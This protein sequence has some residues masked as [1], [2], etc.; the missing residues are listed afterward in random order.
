MQKQRHQLVFLLFRTDL[1]LRVVWLLLV[2][3]H[4]LS[5]LNKDSIEASLFAV[6]VVK[7]LVLHDE[8]VD[9]MN[10]NIASRREGLHSAEAL[11]VNGHGALEAQHP[12][13]ETAED[14]GNTGSRS[15]DHKDIRAVLDKNPGRFEEW[16]DCSKGNSEDGLVDRAY[17]SNALDEVVPAFFVFA[18]V[19][20]SLLWTKLITRGVNVDSRTVKEII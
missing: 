15:I 10:E 20:F 8:T 14:D 13:E 18:F 17:P 1:C 3:A 12:H 6:H 11:D 5:V 9:K 19:L 7:L 2:F 16:K 4:S